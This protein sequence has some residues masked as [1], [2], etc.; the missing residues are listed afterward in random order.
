MDVSGKRE[1]LVDV[2]DNI[3]RDCGLGGDC[4]NSVFM[5]MD[6]IPVYAAYIP[7]EVSI[8]VKDTE[9]NTN[10]L[11]D[12]TDLSLLLKSRLVDSLEAGINYLSGIRDKVKG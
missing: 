9:F 10:T 5:S 2:F 8:T 4:E 3:T 12:V 11:K 1:V 6:R 7:V